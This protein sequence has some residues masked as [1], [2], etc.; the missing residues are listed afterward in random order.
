MLANISPIQL[1]DL[2]DELRN[3]EAEINAFGGTVA[4]IYAYRL[5]G[6]EPYVDSRPYDPNNKWMVEVGL[7][8]AKALYELLCLYADKRDVTIKVNDRKLGKWLLKE[9]VHHRV[10][11]EVIAK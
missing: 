9:I 5:G 10:H 1:V 7:S 11:V 8:R 2:W 6:G 4:E 3:A